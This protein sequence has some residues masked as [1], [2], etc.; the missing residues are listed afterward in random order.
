MGKA[1]AEANPELKQR[2]GEQT[3]LGHVGQADD[4]GGVVAS[5]LSDEMRWGNG[6]RL[7]VA[8]GIHL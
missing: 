4:I 5:L 2:L 6:Q 8:G 3:A 7:K 1:L